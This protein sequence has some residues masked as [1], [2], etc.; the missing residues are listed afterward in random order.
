M[1]KLV[2]PMG[3]M[4]AVTVLSYTINVGL[5]T[6][7]H[8]ALGIAP[9]FAFAVGMASV[10][11]LNFCAFRYVIFDASDGDPRRQFVR[12]IGSALLFRVTDY[13]LFIVVHTIAGV[14]YFVA[15]N[16][17]LVVS[18]FAKFFFFRSVV[19]AP[20]TGSTDD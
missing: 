15:I 14:Q 6:L 7:L 18:F 10:T 8:E 12:F 3:R 9:E 13:L 17:I 19:F 20:H 1:K 11:V 16:A 4:A 2:L 5:T